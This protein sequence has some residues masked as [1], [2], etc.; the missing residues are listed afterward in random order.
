MPPEQEGISREEAD[1]TFVRKD[2]YEADLRTSDLTHVSILDRLLRV[3]TR[4]DRAWRLAWTTLGGPIIIALVVW[5]LNRGG[6]P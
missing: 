2:V 1:R 6:Q 3:E 5:W 4:A